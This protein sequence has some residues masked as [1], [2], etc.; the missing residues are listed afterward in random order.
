MSLSALQNENE[1]YR[2]VKFLKETGYS[3]P[4]ITKECGMESSRR[5]LYKIFKEGHKPSPKILRKIKERFTELDVSY[6][7][8][9]TVNEVSK[10]EEINNKDN[11][12]LMDNTKAL[13]EMKDQLKD[14]VLNQATMTN[15]F[16]QKLNQ[17][18]ESNNKARQQ[19]LDLHQDVLLLMKDIGAWNVVKDKIANHMNDSVESQEIVRDFINT[20]LPPKQ[21]LGKPQTIKKKH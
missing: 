7:L 21:E 2:L 15:H 14:A 19:M 13:N 20:V 17:L 6:I 1:N 10:S 12:Q 5:T 16:F 4:E 11:K 9:G 18:E 3:I 8:T